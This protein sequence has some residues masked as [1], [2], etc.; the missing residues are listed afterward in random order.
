MRFKKLD[1]ATEF[2]IANITK[3]LAK[4]DFT[5]PEMFAELRDMEEVATTSRTIT[6][7]KTMRLMGL[8][9]IAGFQPSKRDRGGNTAALYRLG[10]GIDAVRPRTDYEA[11]YAQRRKDSAARKEKLSAIR[12]EKREAKIDLPIRRNGA[13]VNVQR[14]PMVAA[15]FGS[16]A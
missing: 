15:L 16:A 3:I 1:Y 8:I 10:K 9:H 5:V 2:R 4:G 11:V 14:D 7:L 13:I 6:T 12:T